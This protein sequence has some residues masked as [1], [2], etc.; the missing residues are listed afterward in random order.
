MLR[1]MPDLCL[2]VIACLCLFAC[3]STTENFHKPA[4][5]QPDAPF[6]E[7]RAK[8]IRGTDASVIGVAQTPDTAISQWERMMPEDSTG[9]AVGKLLY[10]MTPWGVATNLVHGKPIVGTTPVF[11]TPTGKVDI[12]VFNY[13]LRTVKKTTSALDGHQ[14]TEN[15]SNPANA[16]PLNA[17]K[18]V[19]TYES[20]HW[21]TCLKVH[22]QPGEKYTLMTKP[23]PTPQSQLEEVNAFVSLIDSN[24]QEAVT[25]H[26]FLVPMENLAFQSFE[27]EQS[28]MVV[29]DPAND[30]VGSSA[31]S[32]LSGVQ[33]GMEASEI[34]A[35]SMKAYGQFIS[36]VEAGKYD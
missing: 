5:L 32:G 26:R 2:L 16:D 17:P 4:S 31:T 22:L 15:I 21:G 7:I 19:Y 18:S 11:K 28:D 1:R 27:K 13:C 14:R 8:G 35:L 10:S 24:G 29:G 20:A 34:L 9:K 23:F 36:D 30:P 33:I 6:A 3:A 25:D 12:L